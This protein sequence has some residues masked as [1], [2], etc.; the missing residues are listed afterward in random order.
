MTR[1]NKTVEDLEREFICGDM[2]ESEFLRSII[3]SILLYK[4]EPLK[5][6]DLVQQ[7]NKPVYDWTDSNMRV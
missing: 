2:G 3:W 6:V 7:I 1:R 5:T 4:N